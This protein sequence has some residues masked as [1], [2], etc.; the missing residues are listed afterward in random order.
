MKPN[1]VKK[2][3]AARTVF[4]I[5]ETHTYMNKKYEMTL[6]SGNKIGSTG[7]L[8]V[9]RLIPKGSKSGTLPAFIFRWD[10]KDD[11]LD[12]DPENAS[13]AV[14][15]EFEKGTSNY[16]GHHTRKIGSDPRVYESDIGWRGQKVYHGQIGFN[17]GWE[18]ELKTAIGLSADLNQTWKRKP[19]GGKK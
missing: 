11:A 19:K 15:K 13:E 16:Y 3:K 5:S 8:D 10:E 7:R 9:A 17:L 18:A 12:I 2:R 4:N 14:I 6:Y 1:E